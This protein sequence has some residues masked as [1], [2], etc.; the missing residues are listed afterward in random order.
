MNLEPHPQIYGVPL[1]GQNWPQSRGVPRIFFLHK[2]S[3]EWGESLDLSKIID[4]LPHGAVVVDIG[5]GSGQMPLHVGGIRSDLHWVLVSAT[6]LDP[7]IEKQ[8][9]DRGSSL[10]YC[11]VPHDLKLLKDHYQDC[12]LVLDTYG[13]ATYDD[14]PD[15]VLLFYALLLSPGGTASIV[16]ST[17]NDQTPTHVFT[18]DET[19]QQIGNFLKENIG[20][21]LK[22]CS[23]KI[24]SQ[25]KPGTY[26]T[27]FLFRLV[28]ED[29]KKEKALNPIELFSIL[30]KK[31]REIIGNPHV[32]ENPWYSS[33]EFK[34]VAK[35]YYK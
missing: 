14:N 32:T 27:D 15:L 26:C 18:F 11:F 29:V 30:S 6:S 2:G 5:T 13:A 24:A 23:K 22:W 16:V 1:P 12:S 28:A 7:V 34:I 25:A 31:L 4:N 9:I 3:K 35:R 33:G 8:M 10:Y 20:V 21:T 17:T 19:L